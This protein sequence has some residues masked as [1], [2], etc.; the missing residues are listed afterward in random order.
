MFN[1]V[2]S[3]AFGKHPAGE[4]SANLSIERYLIDLDKTVGFRFLGIRTRVAYPWCDL[5]GAELD[6]FIDI[7]VKSDDAAGDLVDPRK[8]S[9]SIRESFSI[10]GI[11]R[12]NECQTDSTNLQNVSVFHQYREPEPLI[13]RIAPM[14]IFPVTAP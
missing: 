9:D 7:N 8:F 14:R 3:R 10:G 13:P 2:Q 4:N 5:K 12:D 11:C 1:C 6:C